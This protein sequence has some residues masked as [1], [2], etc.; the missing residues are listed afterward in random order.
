MLHSVK[1]YSQPP[2]N[3]AYQNRPWNRLLLVNHLNQMGQ[4]HI[5]MISCDWPHNIHW[6]IWFI[7][8]GLM[9]Q[10]LLLHF[11][12]LNNDYWTIIET[13][14]GFH[15]YLWWS[16]F[17]ILVLINFSFIPHAHFQLFWRFVRSITITNCCSKLSDK[18]FNLF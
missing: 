9:Q 1:L 10:F 14:H 5:V 17:T 12:L 15:W 2:Y 8:Y 4:D 3:I 7:C 18:C 16:M 13:N 11:K 6:R